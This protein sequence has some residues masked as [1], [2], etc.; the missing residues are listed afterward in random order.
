ML[1]NF[2]KI[3]LY[4]APIRLG[5][6]ILAL[7]LIWLPLAAPI[8][9]LFNSDPNLVTIMTMGLMFIAFLF[10]LQFWGKNVHKQPQLLKHY[11]L[12]WTRQNGIDL[13]KGLSL[14]LWFC[15]GLFILESFL[16]WIEFKTPS[17]GLL[18]VV[19]EGFLS[20]LGIGLAEELVFRGW[21]LDELQ[22]DYQPQTVLWAN[23]IIFAV[24]HFIEPIEEIIR[25]F[26]TFPALI[27][28]GLTLVWSKRVHRDR[29]GICIGI[30]AGLV[31][32]YYILNIGKLVQYSDKVSPWITGIDG[33]PIAGVMGLL[34][35]GILALWMRSKASRNLHGRQSDGE[36]IVK[37]T[38]N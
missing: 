19:A 16:G 9:L 23:A 28:L 29:L 6:F 37:K 8:Y 36:K 18:R 32:G 38:N 25:T 7:L 14:G 17:V 31:W 22:R 15:L 34:F 3:A 11:G 12:V 10:L 33:N 5:I 24:A 30:H 2:S 20:A 4:P 26:L 27:L 13:V 1:E 35:L 21:V